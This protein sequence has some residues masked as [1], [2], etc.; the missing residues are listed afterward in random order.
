M[1]VYELNPVALVGAGPLNKIELDRALRIGSCLVAADGGAETAINHDLV[2]DAVIGDF[3][4]LPDKI[5]SSFPKDRLHRIEEQDS[6]DFD[7]CLRNIHSPLIVAVGFTGAR[8]DHQLAAL[9]TL[10]RHSDKRCIL[11]GPSDAVFLV[12]PSIEID[13]PK[14]TTVSL[15]PMGA[16]EGHSEG[17]RWPIAGI[18]FTP[19]GR[20][21]TSNEATGPVSLSVTAPKM[22][23]TVPAE[24][25]ELTAETL[26]GTKA[27]WSS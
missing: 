5:L 21:G 26:R 13:L 6:T 9:N 24:F 4:S 10:V 3:D 22:L 1:I 19:D 17:L 15:F 18:C 2:P 25:L 7:K 12:P 14:G 27:R 20:I 11:L 16:V 8:M 23:M